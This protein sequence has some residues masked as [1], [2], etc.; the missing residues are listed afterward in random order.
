M[1]KCFSLFVQLINQLI[2]QSINQSI[3]QLPKMLKN[4]AEKKI[5]HNQVVGLHIPQ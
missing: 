1:G 2:N 3:N 4:L 5:A